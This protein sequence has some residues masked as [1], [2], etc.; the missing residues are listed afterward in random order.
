MSNCVP[1]SKIL[2]LSQ[3]R[4]AAEPAEETG[5]FTRAEQM[6]S[7]LRELEASVSLSGI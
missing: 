7:E 6:S 4:G 5:T 3:D 1:I 2:F